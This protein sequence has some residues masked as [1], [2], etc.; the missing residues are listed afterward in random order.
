MKLRSVLLVLLIL[1]CFYLITTHFFPIGTIA[2][3]VHGQPQGQGSI[4]S[5]NINGPMGTFKLTEAPA[6]PS[7]DA[8]EEQ[9]IAVYKRA[10]PS[11][12]NITSTRVAY[13]FFY[14]PVPE[15]G[16][17]SGFILD[18]QGHILT[19]N[20]VVEGA[21]QGSVEVILSNQKRY[22]ATVLGTD[23]AHDLALLQINNAPDLQP[24]ILASSKGLMVG[25]QVYAIGN[26]FG[27]QG[28]MTR[29]IISALRS[30]QLPSGVKIDNAIQ[31]DASV[32]PGNSGGPLLNSHGE[33]IGITTMIAGNPNG[34]AAQSAGIGFAIPIATAKAV[35]DDFAR[36]G[37]VRRPSLDVVTLPID[38]GIAQQIGLPDDYGV[39]IER[40]LPGGAAERA[41]LHGGNQRAYLGF[42]PIVLGG[43][44]IVDID[45]QPITTKQDLSNALNEHHA[46]DTITVTVF[47]GQR[48]FDVKVTLSDASQQQTSQGNET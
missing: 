36:Y 25:Q 15:Q 23:K 13:D 9:N 27:F 4:T 43:D 3:L 19:N 20:H 24:A 21:Q 41:G 18:K 34:G 22:K 2:G 39:L 45:G 16:Q 29:G 31:T 33:V 37:R 11:V 38:P 14:Q 8:D 6:S 42:T 35:I 10:L 30:V 48:R 17:G 47:R 28:T 44:L 7:L 1:G 12:V 26:P 5:A 40:V 46:G 32:N